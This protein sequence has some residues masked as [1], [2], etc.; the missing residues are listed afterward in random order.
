MEC[1]FMQEVA[2]GDFS[3]VLGRIL[4]VHVRDAAVIDAHRQHIDAA[5]LDLIGRMEGGWYTRTAE[6]FEMPTFSLE[7]WRRDLR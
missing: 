5:R 1:R 2:L 3:L 4:L 7:E 6:R